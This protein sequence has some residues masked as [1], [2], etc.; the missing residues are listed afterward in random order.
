MYWDPRERVQ[1]T[2]SSLYSGTFA[3]VYVSSVAMDHQHCLQLQC[4]AAR[5]KISAMSVVC[6]QILHFPFPTPP[7]HD[8]LRS[9]ERTMVAI[10]ALTPKNCILA[11]QTST[12]ADLVLTD[13]GG[14]MVDYPLSPRPSRLI[15]AAA[16]LLQ[17]GRLKDKKL[18]VYAIGLAATLSAESPFLASATRPAAA[19][20]D[21]ADASDKVCMHRSCCILQ[22][23]LLEKHVRLDWT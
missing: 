16:E 21:P 18:L 2:N 15:L 23:S 11:E 9:A 20:Q 7:D 5:K 12:G 8:A 1:T 6:V 10:S 4:D 3:A 17:Q 13:V 22:L 14:A 19:D